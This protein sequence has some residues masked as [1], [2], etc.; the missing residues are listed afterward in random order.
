MTYPELPYLIDLIAPDAER[1][2]RGRRRQSAVW[3]QQAPDCPPIV[4]GRS[5]C[6]QVPDKVGP[7]YLRLCEHQ[8][9]GGRGVPEYHR[10][11]HY[12]LREQ[13]ESPRAMLVES[14]WD[15]I[16]W[17]RTPGDAQLSFRPNFGVGT[18]ASVFG[19]GTDMNENDMPWVNDRPPRARLLD[20]DLDALDRTGLIPRV[21]EF[22]GY[23]REMLTPVPQVHLFMPDLQGPMNTAFLLRQQD[24]FLDMIDDPGWYHRLMEVICEVYIRLTRRLKA[25]LGE[26]LDEGYHGAMYMATGGARV[27][28]DVSIM[29]SPGQYE[30]FSLPYARKCLAPFGGGWVHSC[31]DIS[32]QLDFYLNAPEIKCVNFGEPEKYDFAAVLPRFA[33][34]GKCCYGGPVRMAG[35][36]IESYLARVA[37]YLQ[38]AERTLI[39]MPRY[40]G[41]DMSEGDW[42]APEETVRIWEDAHR[43]PAS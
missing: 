31:G 15:M 35:E 3:R 12:S 22:I 4:L 16:G 8:L 24:I 18:L 36:P 6:R 28:D 43:Q 29:L 21:I 13:F 1:I 30:E 40:G 23:A 38:G 19:C 11:D 41:Q 25:E 39:F 7:Q 33:A 9:R 34:A 10:F 42:P 20:V 2:A 17:A 5:E 37:G 14:L 27:V 32:H 26:P